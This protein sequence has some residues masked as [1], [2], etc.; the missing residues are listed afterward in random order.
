MDENILVK[1]ILEGFLGYLNAKDYDNVESL[2]EALEKFKI[3]KKNVN[4]SVRLVTYLRHGADSQLILTVPNVADAAANVKE[5]LAQYIHFAQKVLCVDSS[6]VKIC[7]SKTV[8]TT[9]KLAQPVRKAM[10][11]MTAACTSTTGLVGG[12]TMNLEQYKGP[13]TAY[14]VALR[15][16]NLKGSLYKPVLR[17]KACNIQKLKDALDTLMGLKTQ[18]VEDF[19]KSFIRQVLSIAATREQPLP[20]P[21]YTA[22]KTENNVS[23]TEGILAKLG[24][25]P[26]VPSTDKIIKIS[27][28]VYKIDENGVP[29]S[30]EAPKDNM[31]LN[32]D[33]EHT[34]AVKLLLPMISVDPKVSLRDQTK[35]PEKYLSE[36]SRKLYSE[37]GP[38]IAETSKAYAILSSCKKGDKKTKPRHVMNICGKVTREISSNLKYQD[39]SGMIY[40]GYMDIPAALR[41][42]IENLTKR[43]TSREK[44][45]RE[46]EPEDEE[47][48][49]D[50]TDSTDMVL[51]APLPKPDSSPKKSKKEKKKAK[52]FT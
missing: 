28:V 50:S 18:G 7:M 48:Q 41:H 26:V 15:A 10:S 16:L 32:R 49:K 6:E 1:D 13:A 36:S 9:C 25:Q 23:S 14:L 52:K 35:H 27:T 2:K 37:N 38:L 8:G 4:K 12:K 21:Y 3:S 31:L 29:Q 20:S 44:R 11:E 17:K 30:V 47:H 46:E 40:S 19:A 43:K 33:K 39:R 34:A 24:Y 51:E 42:H 22:A 5:N 45:P